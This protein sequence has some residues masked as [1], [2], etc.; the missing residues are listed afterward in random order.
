MNKAGVLLCLLS[1][2]LAIP[3]KAQQPLRDGYVSEVLDFES[4]LPCNFVEDMCLDGAGFLW[5]ATSGGLCRYDGYQMLTFNTTSAVS[6][7]SNHL[8]NI[9]VDSLGRLWGGSLNGLDVLDTSTLLP[10]QFPKGDLE[11][12]FTRPVSFLMLDARGALWFKSGESIY[13]TVFSEN[14]AVQE[15]LEYHHPALSRENV[16][17]ADVDRDG[18]VWVGLGGQVFKLRENDGELQATPLL[19]QFRYEDVYL[20]GFLLQGQE[21]WISTENGLY[22]VNRQSGASKHYL[23]NSSNPRSLTQNFISDLARTQD[24]QLI[25]TT[26][27]GI[28]H[29]NTITDDFA[30]EGNDVVNCIR[31]Y[32]ERILVGTETQGLR[33]FSPRRL[34]INNLHHDPS[35]ASSLGPGSVNAVWETPDGTLWVGSVEGGL[36]IR[37]AGEDRFSRLTTRNGLCHNSVSAIRQLPDGRLVVGTWGGGADLVATTGPRRVLRHLRDEEGALAFVGVL[38][39]D[40]DGQHIYIGANSGV[41]VYDLLLDSLTPLL[42]PGAASGCIGSCLDGKGQLWIGCQR[43]LY[44]IDT[45]SP[46]YPARHFGHPLDHPESAAD[47]M[48]CCIL[49]ASDGSFWLGSNGNGVYH[50]RDD[51]ESWQVSRLQT[52]DGL[53]NNRVRSLEEDGEGRIWIS[54]EHGLNVWD[55]LQ[56]TLCSFFR[57]DGLE[58]NQFYW[59]NACKGEDGLLYFGHT[60]GLS[61]VNPLAYTPDRP[62]APLCLTSVQVED[63]ITYDPSPKAVN[64][65]ERDRSLRINFSA[66]TPDVARRI[67]YEYRLQ[68]LDKNWQ[69]LPAPGHEAVFSALPHGSYLFQ[70]RAFSETGKAVGSLD[71]PVNVKAYFYR[72]WWFYLLVIASLL[73]LAYLFLRLR[74]RALIRQREILRNMVEE[75]TREISA[76]KRLVEEKAEELRRQN[77]V[78]LHQNEELASRKLLSFQQEDPFKEKALE[79]LRSLYRDPDLDVNSF[80]QAI[81]MSKTLLNTRLQEAFGQSIGQLVRTFRLTLAREMLESN[82]GMTVSEV[83]YEVGFNDPKYF[84]RCFTKEFGITPSEVPGHKIT[85][86]QKSTL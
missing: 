50:I 61:V 52:R 33:I 86:V 13:R 32:G 81:G 77:D 48:I 58:G 72:T 28:N 63:R 23:H 16:V 22:L 76:Q 25:F 43:G 85:N 59:N 55:P 70:L 69:Q 15:M 11:P 41:Y 39:P 10:A 7:K 2:L 79:T 49:E 26:L 56:E 24:G 14:G 19:S 4:G 45:R 73:G 51:E 29:Y 17:F 42:E 44:I 82:R 83:A 31:V 36:S 62:E 8:H 71:V 46:G 78:L 75:R 60:G 74:M 66:L 57:E 35:S 47:E 6:L 80:C 34:A 84:T 38:E 30:R 5:I 65:H 12:F 9:C 21:V 53:S 20:S 37:N 18:S 54:T 64:L 40:P 27:Y 1:W 67:H 3:V 68:G